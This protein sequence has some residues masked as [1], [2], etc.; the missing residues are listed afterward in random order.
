MATTYTLISSNT[1]S[2]SQASVTFS[3]IPSTYTDLVLKMSV[4]GTYSGTTT[5][6]NLTVNS[7]TSGY[8]QTHLQGNGSS[9]SSSQDVSQA[10]W[11]TYSFNADTST[12]NTFSNIEIY[13][14]SYTASQYKPA[15]QFIAPEQN[16]TTAYISVDAL[17]L[18]NTAAIS[19]ITFDPAF[20]DIASGSSFWL[21]GIRNN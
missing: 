14:P 8:S 10:K 3:S 13:I 5:T 7:I 20:G 11:Y 9:A 4:R 18:S 16:G 21:Y 17:L 2:S 19:S 12:A 15:S 6:A 1:L